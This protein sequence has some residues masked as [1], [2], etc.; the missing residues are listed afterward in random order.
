M[1]IAK[2]LLCLTSLVI[3]TASPAFCAPQ[4]WNFGW[5]AQPESISRLPAKPFMPTE[6]TLPAITAGPQ[7]NVVMAA[8]PRTLQTQDIVPESR[9][10]SGTTT[11]VPKPQSSKIRI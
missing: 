11:G 8:Q 2:L 5:P 4:L 9:L 3:L 6:A 1:A 7:R 10:F